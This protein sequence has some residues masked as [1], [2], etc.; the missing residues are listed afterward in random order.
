V[1]TAA[2]EPRRENRAVMLVGH[3]SWVCGAA[4]VVMTIAADVFGGRYRWLN[5]VG[6]AMWAIWWLALLGADKRYHNAR[7]CERCIT[8]TPLDPQASVDRW[9]RFLRMEHETGRWLGV[10]VVVFGADVWVDSRYSWLTTV[11]DCLFLAVLALTY[12]AEYIHRR[13]YPWCPF[14]RWGDEG[15][16]HEEAPDVPAPT[17]AA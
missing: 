16:D 13:L 9:R 8:A 1:T 12:S 14:C 3:Y 15:G 4:V 5:F 6:L 2:D 11:A 7:L 17:V 10:L